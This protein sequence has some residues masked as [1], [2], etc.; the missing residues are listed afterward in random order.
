MHHINLI[1]QDV[2]GGCD[3]SDGDKVVGQ[4]RAQAD[5]SWAVTVAGTTDIVT[6]TVTHAQHHVQE[7]LA[8]LGDPEGCE[9]ED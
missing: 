1:W 4:V 8:E 9:I 7:M 6:G 2:E 3:G 5:G